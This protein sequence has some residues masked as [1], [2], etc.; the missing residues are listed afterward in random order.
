VWGGI[1][2]MISG[3]IL[4]ILVGILLV[5]W[6]REGFDPDFI[7]KVIFLLFA[8][9]FISFFSFRYSEGQTKSAAFLFSIINIFSLLIVLIVCPTLTR[10][11]SDMKT[12]E[13]GKII[14]RPFSSPSINPLKSE[15]S[16]KPVVER[17]CIGKTCPY[18]QSPIKQGVFVVIY[19]G[20]NIPH[21]KERWEEN[22]GCTTSGCKYAR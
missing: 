9:T 10:K 16:E 22:G 1:S 14:I 21:H 3:I 8:V 5:E 2:K 4:E 12:T 17:Q 18:C 6:K 15:L 11:F 13:R 19:P 20:C 7:P